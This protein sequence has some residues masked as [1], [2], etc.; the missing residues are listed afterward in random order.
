MLKWV[1]ALPAVAFSGSTWAVEE[2]VRSNTS[3]TTWEIYAAVVIAIGLGAAYVAWHQ[4]RE[5]DRHQRRQMKG[6]APT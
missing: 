4:K 5:K 2:A 6:P 1:Q 3:A